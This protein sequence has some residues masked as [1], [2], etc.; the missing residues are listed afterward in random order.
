MMDE[1]ADGDDGDDDD[2]GDDGGDK[3]GKSPKEYI[4]CKVCFCGKVVE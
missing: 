3:E 1:D 2:D 4:F